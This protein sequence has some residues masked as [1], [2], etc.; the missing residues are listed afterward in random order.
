[1]NASVVLT[2]ATGGI[3]A[4]IA[5]RLVARGDRVLLVARSADALARLAHELGHGRAAGTVDALAIDITRAEGRTALVALA[6]RRRCDVL[7]N[8]AGIPSF[9]PIASLSDAHVEQVIAVD[10]VAPILL[11][12]ALLPVL[13]RA[14][15]ATVLNVGS[16]LGRIGLPGFTVY[17]AAKFGVR[18]FSEALRRELAGTRVRVRHL[19]P[20]TTRTA[21]NDARVDAYN[22]ATGARSD[23]PDRVARAAV[24]MID[25]GPAERTLGA[26]EAIAAR[27]NG[28]VPTWLD[29]AFESHRRAVDDPRRPAAVTTLE[30]SE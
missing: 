6:D 22:R 19:A 15:R 21:F 25:R 3:G 23:D 5:R 10:L 1:M 24:A 20:R 26:S 18:G 27:L 29:R 7:V 11:T 17:G 4:A 2:G 16:A 9:G 12:R 14:P 8:N 13:R 30:T 28:L